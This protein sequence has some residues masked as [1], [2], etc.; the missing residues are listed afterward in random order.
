MTLIEVN[1]HSRCSY[2]TDLRRINMNGLLLRMNMAAKSIGMIKMMRLLN[3]NDW[4]IFIYWPKGR[5][6]PGGNLLWWSSMIFL[7]HWQVQRTASSLVQMVWLQK[8]SEL[9]AGLL[10]YGSI[11]CFLCVWVA[12]KPKNLKHGVKSFSLPFQ[13]KPTRWAYSLWDTSVCCLLF[14]NSTFAPCKLP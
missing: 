6:K 3:K 4:F 12:G 9:S 8:W 2:K 5:L 7:T 14:K 11:C 10:C 1:N 13:R